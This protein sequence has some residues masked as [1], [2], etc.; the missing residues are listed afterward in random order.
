[1]EDVDSVILASKMIHEMFHGFQRENGESRFPDELDA[2][3]N[4]SYDA[5]NLEL[6]L[7][8]NRIIASLSESF[9]SEEYKRLSEEN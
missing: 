2:L 4:Y 1:M 9:D 6:K 5:C 3:Y 7:I 8:E